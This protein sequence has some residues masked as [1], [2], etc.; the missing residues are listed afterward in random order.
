MLGWLGAIDEL[1]RG[2]HTG[3]ELGARETNGLQLRRMVPAAVVLGGLYGFFMGWFS[4][5]N[6]AELAGAQMLASMVKVP[7]LFLLTLIVTFPSLYVFNALLGSRLGFVATLRLLVG[8]ITV[9][10]AVAASLGPILAFFT[11][12]TESYVFTVL[13]NVGLLGLSGVIGCV[14]LLKALRAVSASP[15]APDDLAGVSTPDASSGDIA[16]TTSRVWVGLFGIVGLQMGWV[17]RPFIGAPGRPFE[18]LRSTQSHVFEAIWRLVTS[19][20]MGGG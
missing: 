15:P 16:L 10:L 14:F 7:L 8:S 12:S 9:I 18:L 20:I 17:L 19:P 13:L 5:R 6:G 3:P 1:L 4:V 2:R 11:V